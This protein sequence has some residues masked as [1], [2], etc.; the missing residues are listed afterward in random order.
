MVI[1]ALAARRAAAARSVRAWSAGCA[2][3]EEPYTLAMML[4]RGAAARG[5]LA[6]RRAGDRRQRERARARARRAATRRRRS[7]SVPDAIASWRVR[8]ADGGRVR[9]VAGDRGAGA[10]SSST[11]WL[12]ADVPARVRPGAGAAT[13]SSTSTRA[14]ARRQVVKR[15][16]ESAGPGRLPVRRLR[17]D[18]ARLRRARGGAH[19]RTRCS[20]ASRP[21]PTRPR[22]EPERRAPP[23]A[24]RGR[25]AGQAGEPARRRPRRPAT[26]PAAR[27]DVL[28]AGAAREPRAARRGAGRA[29]A[30]G[31]RSSS[32]RGRY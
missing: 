14:Q 30:R 27:R 12:D 5:R 16:V 25:R 31:A 29:P 18:A 1:P 6:A 11:T 2:G 15:L 22:T 26:A 32:C 28:V 21:A 17:R 20:T 19:R 23:A 9:V 7:R 8:A 13:C 24:R 4:A 3:G 10:A